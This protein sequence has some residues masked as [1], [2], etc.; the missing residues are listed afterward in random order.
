MV[1]HHQ[2]MTT[3]T[4]RPAL[5]R[6]FASPS[7]GR[8]C[9]SLPRRLTKTTEG[10][11]TGPPAAPPQA[12]GAHFSPGPRGA[13]RWQQEHTHVTRTGEHR[14][15]GRHPRLSHVPVGAQ[16]PPGEGTLTCAYTWL[17]TAAPGGATRTRPSCTEAQTTLRPHTV[18]AHGHEH[19]LKGT[20]RAHMTHTHTP[21]CTLTRTPSAACP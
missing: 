20:D 14:R 7:N 9:G 1:R 15:K 13:S 19:V 12:T 3:G 6:G 2:R 17:C 10:A 18:D 21:R 11:R 8:R 4:S 5:Q 16:L